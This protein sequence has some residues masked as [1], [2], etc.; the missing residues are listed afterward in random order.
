MKKIINYSLYLIIFLITLFSVNNVYAKNLTSGFTVTDLKLCKDIECANPYNST[1]NPK[2]SAATAYLITSWKYN[3]ESISAGDYIEVE[4][5]NNPLTATSS[6]WSGSTSTETDNLDVNGIKIGKWYTTGS[7]TSKKLRIEFNEK[8]ANLSTVEGTLISG[9]NVYDFYRSYTDRLGNDAIPLTVH[10]KTIKIGIIGNPIQKLEIDN[11]YL[12]GSVGNDTNTYF[13]G[14][15]TPSF[16]KDLYEGKTTYTDKTCKKLTYEL[17]IPSNVTIKNSNFELPF[18]DIYQDDTGN[19]VANAV[20]YSPTTGTHFKKITNNGMTYEEF[21][22]SLNPFEYGYYDNGNGSGGKLIVNFGDFP[23]TSKKYMDFEH[24]ND[25]GSVGEYLYNYNPYTLEEE[26]IN[27]FNQIYGESNT[28][29]KGKVFI[30]R[31]SINLTFPQVYENKKVTTTATWT[32]IPK[33]GSPLIYN[34]SGSGSL[35]P[36]SAIATVKG[37]VKFLKIDKDSQLAIKGAKFKLSKKNGS[38]WTV[39]DNNLITDESGYFA[40]DG[41]ENG[42]YKLEEITYPAHYKSNSLKMYS[43]SERTTEITSETTFTIDNNGKVIYAT[44]ER[45]EF[46][47]TFKKGTKGNFEDK[48]YTVK[49][50]DPTPSFSPTTDTDWTF[51]KWTPSIQS[52]VTAN[53]TYTALWEKKADITEHYYILGT[54]NELKPDKITEGINVGSSYS[55]TRDDTGISSDY[56]YKST[57]GS[58]S[59]TMSESGIEITHYYKAITPTCVGSDEVYQAKGYTG[60]NLWEI[61]SPNNKFRG[62][63]INLNRHSPNNSYYCKREADNQS[64]VNG[65]L[66][67]SSDHCYEPLGSNMKEAMIALIY[68]GATQSQIWDFTNRCSRMASSTRTWA[69]QH[70]YS[71]IPEEIRNNYKLYIYESQNNPK[72][73][74]FLTIEGVLEEAK[75]GVIVNKTSDDNRLL[76]DAVFT[77][78]DSNNQAIRTITSINGE[79]GLYRTDRNTGLPL[80]TYTIKETTAPAGYKKSDDSYTFTISE[81]QQH[82]RVGKKN[83]SGSNVEMNFLNKKINDYKG[84]GVEVKKTGLGNKLLPGAEFTIYNSTGGEVKKIYTNQNGIAK[85][86]IKDLALGTYK[87]KETKAPIGYHLSTEEKQIKIENDSVYVTGITFSDTTKTGTI[88]LEATKKMAKGEMGAYQFQLIDENNRVIQTKTNNTTTGKITFDSISYN[89]DDIGY[90]KYKIKEVKGN[91]EDITYDEHTEEVMVYI[92]DDRNT[93]LKVYAEYDNDGAIFTNTNGKVKKGNLKITKET[94]GENKDVLTSFKVNITCDKTD[95]TGTFGDIKFT[96]GKATV[97]LAGGESKSATGIEEGVKCSIAEEDYSSYHYQTSISENNITIVKNETKEVKITNTHTEEKINIKVNKVWNDSNNLAGKRPNSITVNLLADNTKVDEIVLSQANNFTS[98]F[99]NK[100]KY[101]GNKEIVYTISEVTP[102]GYTS[103]IT[104]DKASGFTITN[105]YKS[106]S[107]KITKKT[108][109]ENADI[110]NSFGITITLSDNTI[111]GKFGDVT[112]TNGSSHISLGN[113]GSKTISNLPEGIKVTVKEDDYSDYEYTTSISGNNVNVVKDQTKDIIITNTRNPQKININFTKVWNDTNNQDGIRPNKIKVN[114]YADGTKVD[115]KDLTT[116]SGSFTN[117]PKKNGNKV[118]TYTI[119]EDTVTGYTP[120]I[121]GNQ[122]NGFTITNKQNEYEKTSVTVLKNWDDEENKDGVRPDKITVHLLADGEKIKQQEITEEMNWTYTF[123]NLDK[124][125]AG[126]E[127]KYTIT[128]DEIK[129]YE[130]TIDG[131]NI[132]NTHIPEKRNIT[133]EKVWDDF[134]NEDKIRPDKI[135]VNLLANGVVIDHREGLKENNYKVE[136]N[137]IYTYQDGKE[138]KYTIEEELV[139]EYSYIIDNLTQIEEENNE[140]EQSDT[141][142]KENLDFKI[143]NKHELRPKVENNNVQSNPITSSLIKIAT[144]I[145]LIGLSSILIINRKGIKI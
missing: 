144:L 16:L 64:L 80:G 136:F 66:L 27:I 35:R 77:I 117:L 59:G 90:I 124:N 68:Y 47:I 43:N 25:A 105:T 127:I 23:S 100:P 135:T 95:M 21:K 70:K 98:S 129:Y 11:W 2:A 87:I 130:T 82:V 133:V 113:N 102:T 85:T 13:V 74:N 97:S 118:I 71:T 143:T 84:G 134:N 88:Q 101:N 29:S 99:Q 9:Y 48:T 24:I 17:D 128:E 10:N 1:S 140:T 20:I 138:I 139:E 15:T 110:I 22:N 121:T 112:F 42:D 4:Y 137:D 106:G 51:T 83:G 116:T 12:G 115:S 7:G 131:F 73:Q 52:S 79:A 81:N 61:H 40:K 26:K 119:K 36:S 111:S 50:G 46:T 125:K 39:I 14:Q 122:T 3:G 19:S 5:L 94:K 96:S 60:E 107:V 109:G 76:T 120:T 93:N 38:S 54:T 57:T 78:Y 126:K 28:L 91:D 65:D 58:M 69:E 114:L 37:Q 49:Y 34:L 104:G 63:C 141:I 62:Y 145:I 142:K 86:G 103:S 31:P 41:L 56:E 132:T 53:A 55:L 6:T 75:G 33:T 30:W 8:A 32:C 44:N 92:E 67:S 123:D 72:D 18:F 108:A 89:A 45:E